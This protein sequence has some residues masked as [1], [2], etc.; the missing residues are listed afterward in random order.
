[1]KKYIVLPLLLLYFGNPLILRADFTGD[2]NNDD[3]IG[4]VEAVYPLQALAEQRDLL[5]TDTNIKDIIEILQRL[6]LIP[7]QTDLELFGKPSISS[8]DPKN[9]SPGTLVTIAGHN[10]VPW[11]SAENLV[12][13]AGESAQVISSTTTQMIVRVPDGADTGPITLMTPEGSCTSSEDF[14]ITKDF[15]FVFNPP[16][17]EQRQFSLYTPFGDV[18]PVS[19]GLTQ[20]AVDKDYWT[21]IN[22]L[23]PG[24][25]NLVYMKIHFPDQEGTT[26]QA[27]TSETI[28]ALS[29]AKSL[30]F[31]SPFF[32]TCDLNDA[33]MLMDIIDTDAA[34][35][36]L[37]QIIE[38]LYPNTD[39]PFT[40][41][42]FKNAL[43][44]AMTSVAERI[45]KDYKPNKTQATG[46]RT[47][48]EA[49]VTGSVY[50]KDIRTL[51]IERIT[52]EESYSESIC[53]DID[54]VQTN[55][56]DWIVRISQIE[57]KKLYDLFPNGAYS[58][59][60]ADPLISYPREPDGFFAKEA[61]MPK[62][63][64][65]RFAII[66][67]LMSDLVDTLDFTGAGGDTRIELPD[68]EGVYIVRAFAPIF[69]RTVD[70][71]ELS[72]IRNSPEFAPGQVDF[73]KA[74]GQNMVMMTV[75]IIDGALGIFNIFESDSRREVLRAALAA[76]DRA[77]A[78]EFES[79]IDQPVTDIARL[80]RLSNILSDVVDAFFKQCITE[81]VN[82]GYAKVEAMAKKAGGT[83]GSVAK[84]ASGV[85]AITDAISYL[86]PVGER[87]GGMA[88]I[89]LMEHFGLDLSPMET[90]FVVVGAPFEWEV[91]KIIKKE[92]SPG[93]IITLKGKK[94]DHRDKD[95]NEIWLGD[96]PEFG[97]E[98]AEVLSVN[99]D[100]TEL[101]FKIPEDQKEGSLDIYFKTS[102]CKDK[103]GTIT[104]KRIPKLKNL[105]PDKGFA[106]VP[107][108][109]QG[110]FAYFKGTNVKLTGYGF[111]PSDTVFF[112]AS[113]VEAD[114]SETATELHR[115]V[116]IL[117]VG[118]KTVY[119]KS[120]D[121]NIESER[122]SFTVLDKPVLSAI[123]PAEASIGQ[124]VTITGQNFGAETDEVKIE[125]SDCNG[126][127]NVVSVENDKIVFKMPAAGQP[128]DTLQVKVLTPAGESGTVDID[129]TPGV[130]IPDHPDFPDGYTISVNAIG[131]GINPDGKISLDEAAAFA[132]GDE[133]PFD[134]AGGWDDRDVKYTTHYRQ[135]KYL[136]DDKPHYRWVK[137]HVNGPEYLSAHA[138][139]EYQYNYRVDHYHAD[140]GGNV[141]DP[142][143]TSK[144][145]LDATETEME[146]GDYVTG[147]HGGK[148]YKDTIVFTDG[149]ATYKSANFEL[150]DWDIVNGE[151]VNI[152]L[153]SNPITLKHKNHVK[154][155]ELQI[156][157]ASIRITGDS[158]YLKADLKNISNNAVTIENG[159]DN[160]LNI[161][162]D[163]CSGHGVY[164][165]NGHKNQIHLNNG[166]IQNCQGD[167]IRIENGEENNITVRNIRHCA[168]NGIT[169]NG[170]RNNKIQ[171]FYEPYYNFDDVVIDGCF[172]GI[173]IADTIGNS[174]FSIAVKNSS[175]SGIYIHG[176]ELNAIGTTIGGWGKTTIS[177]NLGHGVELSKTRRNSFDV[178]SLNNK[179][180]GI[181]LADG[182][183][184]NNIKGVISGNKNGIVLE[185][186]KTNGNDLSHPCTIEDNDIYGVHICSG[187]HSNTVSSAIDKNGSHGVFIE[188][189]ETAYNTVSGNNISYNQGDGVRIAGGA[190]HNTLYHSTVFYNEN[191]IAIRGQGTNFNKVTGMDMGMNTMTIH[192]NKGVGVLVS[193]GAVGT[194]IKGTYLYR[195]LGGSIILSGIT[196]QW[197]ENEKPWNLAH[198]HDCGVG[199]FNPRYNEP[200][201]GT[202][203][204]GI[205]LEKGTTNVLVEDCVIGGHDTGIMLKDEGTLNNYFDAMDLWK[206]NGVGVKIED[207]QDNAFNRLSIKGTSSHGVSILKGKNNK[208]H[209]HTYFTNI[210]K[211]VFHLS[212]TDGTKI[213][214]NDA[215]YYGSGMIIEGCRNVLVSGMHFESDGNGIEIKNSHHT[216]LIE[217]GG[218]DCGGD[219]VLITG[220]SEDTQIDNL[221][222]S[223][224]GGA[225]LHIINAKD[226]KV[227]GWTSNH[228]QIGILIDQAQDVHIEGGETP[229]YYAGAEYNE[230]QGIFIKGA[231]TDNVHIIDSIITGNSAEGIRV[232]NGKN[233]WI[234]GATG[235][236]ISDNPIGVLAQGADT[237]LWIIKNSIGEWTRVSEGFSSFGP[238]PG[239]AVGIQLQGGIS[240]AKI[241]NNT[242]RINDAEGIILKDGACGNRISSN[243]ITRNGAGGVLVQGESTKNNAIPS[244]AITD[245]TGKGI[246]LAGGNNMIEPP[247][248]S[249]ISQHTVSGNANAPKGSFV[250]VYADP[251]DE[252]EKLIGSSR[253]L[254]NSFSISANMPLGK[255]F[256][257]IVIDPDGNTSE[258]GPVVIND[259]SLRMNN[260]IFTSTTDGSQEIYA[261]QGEELKRLT[262]NEFS[263]SS[264]KLYPDGNNIL[265]VSDRSGNTD[266]WTM[267]KDGTNQAPFTVNSEADYDPALF[268]D[269]DKMLFAS[270]R[271]GDAEIYIMKITPGAPV[272]G[273]AY[274]N[275]EPDS[276]QIQPKNCGSGVHFTTGQ[277][278]LAQIKFYIDG[279]PAEFKWAVLDWTDGKPGQVMA[280][281]TTLPENTGWH[282]VD[283]DDIEI[284]SDFVVA[285]FYL[286]DNQPKLG[287]DNCEP[288]DRRAWFYSPDSWFNDWNGDYM[289]RAV[290]IPS[291]QRLTENN[292]VDRYPACSP[293]GAKIVFASDRNGNMD[294]WV[295]DADGKN[296]T[297]LIATPGAAEIQP[298]WSPDGSRIA[299]TSD[300]SG[301]RDIWIMNADGTSPQNLTNSTVPEQDPF[302]TKGNDILFASDR[303]GGW[304]IYQMQADGRN[305]K[306]LTTLFGDTIQP[307]AK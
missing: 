271:D 62:A 17:N 131:A 22:A 200:D 77:I 250:E 302:W 141:S 76:C 42:A 71:G 48:M 157:N 151:N 278:A 259:G 173:E 160:Y 57:Q 58:L 184:E 145:D 185:G 154:L 18:R 258:F 133:N 135:D 174:V 102:Y 288:I 252:G 11:Y 166:G 129:R 13:F 204:N 96:I 125:I 59:T 84:V 8:F 39:D 304:E 281:G 232:E 287:V 230:Q 20:A 164:I 19:A 132:R 183:V 50:G 123:E 10:F 161:S 34:V 107:E 119:V 171:G 55:P 290:V 196:K 40:D 45:P 97:G 202:V 118:K 207:A 88:G 260:Y 253:L 177:E 168:G 4:I 99:S 14:I 158:N 190:H 90:A 293:D 219:G 203:G 198:V 12:L 163:T 178:T 95:N 221:Q 128:G 213:A 262:E 244:N 282:T 41:D 249:Y 297:P 98:K 94:F 86:G 75:D 37:A 110:Y 276:Y 69:D 206:I 217:A 153:I 148:G 53:I 78:R 245:N 21:L 89:G 101:K 189:G 169:V 144:E 162:I 254:G 80:R 224:N 29:T 66:T 137:S 16:A 300:A 134:Y 181:H 188:G 210:D 235:N 65:R 228:N 67:T 3:K 208:F 31:M 91:D 295:M 142:Y 257:A 139:K 239:N 159:I 172:Y 263:D 30:V 28:D 74:T 143:L 179:G 283:T 175:K 114:G 248:I 269:G 236:F 218:F 222:S 170:G 73:D 305:V 225:G 220:G 104:I 301:N 83:L 1:M 199:L 49:S 182:S 147:S 294:I 60:N 266:I 272:G 23:D 127:A 36:Q 56:M 72:F 226:V 115:H 273:V 205:T 27:V 289:I 116:P 120:N 307:S 100:G 268:P 247:V 291:T 186:P 223:R 33:R 38:G 70:G 54:T 68:K 106:A 261:Y 138:G 51:N 5:E 270:E 292:A 109:T 229:D 241:T 6:T 197:E 234:G 140:N 251:D 63:I 108:G 255:S 113:E 82:Q 275:G 231:T 192:D 47:S 46:M 7:A 103:A 15:N 227:R 277:G 9:G 306:R 238:Y 155:G 256:H 286:S 2:I 191:G 167:G 237:R 176:G 265:F 105:D 124:Y 279:D 136:V 299:F 187:A 44:A 193:G 211:D 246:R 194:E 156:K 26:S 214:V 242:I 152:S 298:V 85:L 111:S 24:E 180:D 35:A 149:E 280:E 212:Q 122:L 93:E 150:G 126:F 81:A 146:E 43:A 296:Q 233:I 285:M 25:N 209:G 117:S 165:K 216:R 215:W 61:R 267:E 79:G 32:V 92:A 240:N 243:T 303:E 195:N 64:T 121:Y 284:T 264:P 201:E 52:N 274:D 130:A 87:L 112:D